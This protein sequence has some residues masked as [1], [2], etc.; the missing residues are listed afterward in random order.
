MTFQPTFKIAALFLAWAS[1][2]LALGHVTLENQTAKAGSGYKAVF[3]VGH[4]CEGSPTRSIR[5][6]LPSGFKGAKPMP[7]PGWVL[8]TRRE[9]LAVPYSSHGKTI[10]QDVVEVTW[11]VASAANALPDA[12]YDEFVLRGT[13]P[14]TVGPLWFKVLQRCT[15][16]QNDWA[17]VPATGTSTKGM[18]APAALLN[19][20]AAAPV[21]AA[22]HQH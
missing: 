19:V 15:K 11:A 16:G 14:D 17:E 2:P 21:T 18:K 3:R 1:T 4:G 9:T 6:S 12:H 10:S 13:L 22:P 8:T 5:V 7:K 20:E